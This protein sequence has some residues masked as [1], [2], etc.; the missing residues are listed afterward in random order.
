MGRE[1][2]GGTGEGGTGEGGGRGEAVG[3]P[4]RRRYWVSCVGVLGS[5]RITKN[6]CKN[7]LEHFYIYN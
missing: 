1:P 2:E 3:V 4:A 5:G 6:S 7:L